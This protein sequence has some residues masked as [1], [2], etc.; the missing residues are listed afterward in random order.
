MK[1]ELEVSQEEWDAVLRGARRGLVDVIDGATMR[2][3]DSLLVEE[4]RCVHI[5]FC[6]PLVAAASVAA[7]RELPDGVHVRVWLLPGRKEGHG[8]DSGC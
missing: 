6:S 1:L 8:S 7:D 2:L 4:C 5:E 3:R